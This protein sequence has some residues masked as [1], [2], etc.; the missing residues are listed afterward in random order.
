MSSFQ[1]LDGKK[2]AEAGMGMGTF[3]TELPLLKIGATAV[4]LDKLDL[5]GL[6]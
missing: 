2:I 3:F 4:V 6:G 5:N 1:A